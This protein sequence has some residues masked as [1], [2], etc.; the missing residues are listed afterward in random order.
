MKWTNYSWGVVGLAVLIGLAA[1]DPLGAP[2][3]TPVPGIT[4]RPMSILPLHYERSGGF[5]G[6]QEGLD[7]GAD[8]TVTVTQRGQ[9]AV[10]G[11]LDAQQLAAVQTAG[12]AALAVSPAIQY[13][14]AAPDAFVYN[15]TLGPTARKITVAESEGPVPTPPA[16][17]TFVALLTQVRAAVPAGLNAGP[18]PTQ[19]RVASILPLH[20]ERSGG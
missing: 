8:G 1:C 10:T 11:H 12:A 6:V 18:S 15:L 7:I 14:I 16:L 5:A 4:P 20:Y 9:R 3:V 2:G 17:L 13:G 19:A